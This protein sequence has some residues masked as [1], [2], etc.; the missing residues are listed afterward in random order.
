MDR[1]NI[2][3]DQNVIH[4]FKASLQHERDQAAKA[5]RFYLEVLKVSEIQRFNSDSDADMEMQRQDVDLILTLN[6]INYRVSEKFRDKDF[7]DLYVEVYSKY[8]KTFGWLHT[9]TPNAILYFTPEQVYWITHQ[10]L[11][12]FCIEILFPCISDGWF[13]EL[14]LSPKSIISKQLV[15]KNNQYKINLIQAHNHDSAD[16]ETL[17]ISAPFELFEDFGVKIRKCKCKN[18][19]DNTSL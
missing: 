3:T 10:S 9:G 11:S 15:L 16:W 7:G 5:D 12:T 17:G 14:I 18:S 13:E 1:E 6:N 4:N 19:L 8:P 2:K